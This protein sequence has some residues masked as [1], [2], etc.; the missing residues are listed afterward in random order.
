MDSQW[1][2]LRE[3]MLELLQKELRFNR[4]VKTEYQVMVIGIPNVCFFSFFI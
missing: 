2:A 1:D 3:K 4:T